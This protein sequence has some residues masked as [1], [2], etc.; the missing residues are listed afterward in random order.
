MA[1]TS[2]LPPT[3]LGAPLYLCPA[4]SSSAATQALPIPH[5]VRRVL[6]AN[7]GEIAL[8][9]IKTCQALGIST[10]A[11]YVSE[12]CD[13]PHVLAADRAICLGSI[14]QHG[15]SGRPPPY[16]D[17]ELLI[18]T[19][20][21][22]DCDALHPGYGYLSEQADFA[23]K[24][25]STALPDDSSRKLCFIGPKGEVMRQM[26][27]KA[28]SK[29]LLRSRLGA[30][31]APLV[32]GYESEKTPEG[33]K[34]EVLVQEAR[35]IGFPVLLK[36]SAGGGG[37]GIRIVRDSASLPEEIS[38]AQ[39]EAQRSFGSPHLLIEKYIENG[40]HIEVQIFGDNYGNVIA[41]GEREC[42][43]QRRHQ[44]IIEESPCMEMS[45]FPELRKDLHASA[46]LIGKLLAYQGAAT[47]EYIYSS[48]LKRFYFLEINTRLQVEHPVTECVYG[49]DLVSLQLYVA[50]GGDIS[51]LSDV[52][53]RARRPPVGHAIEMRLCAEEPGAEFA[54][55]TGYV[56]HISAPLAVSRPGYRLDSGVVTGS[57]VSIHFDPM[58]AKLIVHAPDRAAAIRA[59]RQM[60]ECTPVLGVTT[61]T[62]FIHACLGHPAFT[63]G[64]YSTSL[65]P[66]NIDS[67]LGHGSS[68]AMRALMLNNSLAP[69][70]LEREIP[71]HAALPTFLFFHAIRKRLRP[72]RVGLKQSWRL[73]N[74]DV[75]LHQT[76][77]YVITLPGNVQMWDIMLQY[78]PL[79]LQTAWA[80]S[81]GGSS[82]E[83]FE[84]MLWHNDAAHDT[85]KQVLK[86]LV[87]QAKAKAAEKGKRNG[88]AG[89]GTTTAPTLPQLRTAATARY[90]AS[91]PSRAGVEGRP[92]VSDEVKADS[93]GRPKASWPFGVAPD[94]VQRVRVTVRPNGASIG[95][96]LTHVR[97]LDG[98]AQWLNGAVRYEVQLLSE[99]PEVSS[100]TPSTTHFSVLASDEHFEAHEECSQ[101]AW[102]WLPA[103][104]GQVKVIRRS[105]RVY[106][107]RL[108][109]GQAAGSADES[110]Y[111][112]PMPCRI[113][114]LIAKDGQSV[115]PGE[116]I[117][118]MESMKTE[119]KLL[120][121]SAG[122]LRLLVKEGDT[123][124]EG[125][126][127]CVVD[128][129]M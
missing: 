101:F 13:G 110:T 84:V 81:A 21:D 34:M 49:I 56:R 7:R 1:T 90:Y 76:E 97:A 108:E 42:S 125:Q 112:T 59:A 85:E 71:I 96:E 3:Y 20:L 78:R 28:N 10:V 6:I 12:D 106:A 116:S 26:G 67:L 19:A 74:A 35:K 62:A 122:T 16:L 11:V 109:E 5:P 64:S 52:A 70:A 73:H 66:Q 30:D 58:L 123:I 27:E 50:G 93:K 99:L 77:N 75:S 63:G 104:A 39:S 54:P 33:Q 37:K 117:L 8:R 47:I 61:N 118:V 43:V 18:K 87:D 127:L 107:G 115:K 68:A 124:G 9:I 91:L 98:A 45:N 32:P 113:L 65:I 100:T 17:G 114:H 82:G 22:N 57:N 69:A 2:P 128:S 119:I 14:E 15:I 95:P 38:R 25:A 120:A 55:R 83:S 23:D 53:E 129:N 48:A 105:L 72:A 89:S 4:T 126:A 24:V 88:N 41:L 79:P 44:K 40:K 60:L 102:L 111:S 121:R 92:A 80:A 31:K 94:A 46:V 103:I 51:N 29:V 86:G 36:A